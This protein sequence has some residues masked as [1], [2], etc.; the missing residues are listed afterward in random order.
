MIKYKNVIAIIINEPQLLNFNIYLINVIVYMVLS[1]VCFSRSSLHVK[2]EE[3]YEMNV[4]RLLIINLY[5]KKLN[6]K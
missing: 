6:G 2:F 5:L 1:I 4:H 3:K